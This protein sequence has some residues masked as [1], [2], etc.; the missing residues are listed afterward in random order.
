M[1][2]L[3]AIRVRSDIERKRMFGLDETEDSGSG[4]AQGIYA[5]D[6]SEAVYERLNNIAASILE[7]GHDVI[8]DAAFLSAA[9]REQARRTAQDC[10]AGYHI[11]ETVAPVDTLRERI[12]AR[13]KDGKDA[14]EGNLAVLDY[15][16][17]NAA[18]LSEL[19]REATTT[20]NTT[21]E[22]NVEALAIGIRSGARAPAGESGT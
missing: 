1:A 13:Q 16:L 3:P 10:A 21:E 6:A 8:L 4:V 20:W 9:E 17:E 14:S 12:Q 11:L 18:L 5:P 22:A 19:E 15:Q 2:A 7:S